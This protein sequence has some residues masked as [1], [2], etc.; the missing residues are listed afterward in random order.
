[1]R[2]T[3]TI[4]G[5]ILVA[6]VT[7]LCGGVVGA[8]RHVGDQAAE[9]L[10]KPGS[11]DGM[12]G[13]FWLVWLYDKTVGLP[14]SKPFHP[15]RVELAERFLDA[16]EDGMP[17]AAQSLAMGDVTGA[18]SVAR[19]RESIDRLGPADP[20]PGRRAMS[21]GMDLTYRKPMSIGSR[22]VISYYRNHERG[23]TGTS[24]GVVR[25]PDGLRVDE[26]TVDLRPYRME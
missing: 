6:L 4:A 21:S 22:V 25:T 10:R 18:I 20:L 14:P 23:S 2:R 19:Y 13:L 16:V 7:C 11:K 5:L 1:M 12:G 17:A 9:E 8:V 24:V 26:Y 3:L 15:Q